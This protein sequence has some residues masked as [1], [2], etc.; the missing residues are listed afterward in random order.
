MSEHLTAG[1]ISEWTAGERNPE[2]ERHLRA[3]AACRS[4]IDDFQKV[5]AGFQGAVRAW[6]NTQC[7]D[8]SRLAWRAENRAQQRVQPRV[9]WMAAAAAFCALIAIL[10]FHGSV[11]HQV[12]SSEAHTSTSDATLMRQVDTE[13]S[14]TV[15]DA[16]EP[17]M[18]LVSWD[19][20]SSAEEGSPSKQ[21]PK[22]KE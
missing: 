18:K 11:P 20:P 17:L 4:E 10:V 9:Y 15:P 5:L 2:L 3:C 16:M 19:G 14:Q 12:L 1:Q 13:V 22:R 8:G 21:S 7:E 6:S